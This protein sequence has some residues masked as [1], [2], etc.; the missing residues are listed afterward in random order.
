MSDLTRD[1]D[2]ATEVSEPKATA[3]LTPRGM[4]AMQGD[5]SG[6]EALQQRVAAVRAETEAR[7]AAELA[8]LQAQK[9]AQLPLQPDPGSPPPD[10]PAVPT[11]TAP[12]EPPTAPVAPQP[13]RAGHH[14]EV[15][16]NPENEPVDEKPLR[17]TLYRPGN[18]EK[19]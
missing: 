12:A 14:P 8:Q 1:N 11:P 17:E 6:V 13:N 7:E 16:D 2:S 10:V 19:G 4:A 3:K 5:A 9:E 18:P 15:L